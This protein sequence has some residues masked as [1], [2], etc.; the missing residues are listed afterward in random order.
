MELLDAPPGL[1]QLNLDHTVIR[2][3]IDGNQFKRRTESEHSRQHQPPIQHCIDR[4]KTSVLDWVTF[5]ET[6]DDELS[7][8][9]IL[10]TPDLDSQDSLL[11]EILKR[12]QANLPQRRI[13]RKRNKKHHKH[14]QGFVALLSLD[15][16]TARSVAN[17]SISIETLTDRLT[18]RFPSLEKLWT[19]QQQRFKKPETFVRNLRERLQKLEKSRLD[20][21]ADLSRIEYQ[22]ERDNLFFQQIPR[23][24]P[25]LVGK[26]SSFD[27]IDLVKNDDG[28]TDSPHAVKQAV[29][30]N[31]K[32]WTPPAAPFN[33]SS[34]NEWISYYNTHPNVP[35]DFST[36]LLRPVEQ[37]EINTVASST[38]SYKAPGPSGIQAASV[39]QGMNILGPILASLFTRC[40]QAGRI[41]GAWTKSHVHPITKPGATKGDFSKLRPIALLETVRKIFFRVLVNRI[42]DPLHL[43][44]TFCPWQ[45]GFT[46]GLQCPYAISTIRSVID[47]HNREKRPLFLVSFDIR[48]AFDSVS[49]PSLLASLRRFGIPQELQDITTFMY[50]HRKA[51]VH[52]AFGLT[53]PFQPNNGLDQGDTLSPLLWIIFYDALLRRIDDSKLGVVLDFDKRPV[54]N[55]NRINDIILSGLAVADDLTLLA[56]S[57]E[58]AL[59]LIR[60]VDT[61]LQLHGITCNGDKSVIACNHPR[62]HPDFPVPVDMDSSPGRPVSDIRSKDQPVKILG[63]LLRLDG[64]STDAITQMKSRAAGL[65]NAFRYRQ[66]SS[67]IV[68]YFANGVLLP[69]IAWRAWG[70]TFTEAQVQSIA[71][72][73]R[74]TLKNKMRLPSTTPNI[75]L[76]SDETYKVKPLQDIIDEMNIGL[77]ID[78]LNLDHPCTTVLLQDLLSFQYSIGRE[79]FPLAAVRHIKPLP[80]DRLHMVLHRLSTRELTIRPSPSESR[81]LKP[82][83]TGPPIELL[84][85]PDTPTSDL[86]AYTR[87]SQNNTISL[88]D[89]DAPQIPVVIPIIYNHRRI[90]VKVSQAIEKLR[91]FAYDCSKINSNELVRILKDPADPA[92][93]I[94]YPDRGIPSI[95]RSDRPDNHASCSYPLGYP[96]IT[97]NQP[98]QARRTTRPQTPS[99]ELLQEA[100]PAQIEPIDPETYLYKFKTPRGQI[101]LTKDA[102][103]QCARH[104]LTDEY[105]SWAR[106]NADFHVY[107]DGSV[108]GSR[109]GYALAFKQYTADINFTT[110]SHGFDGP[111]ITSNRTE[112][113]AILHAVTLFSNASTLLIQ[114][115]SNV[116]VLAF[117]LFITQN[118]RWSNR[119]KLNHPDAIIWFLVAQIINETGLNVK[120]KHI[121][122][123]TGIPG[124]EQADVTAKK[125]ARNNYGYIWNLNAAY[126]NEQ[127]FLLTVLG[128]HTTRPVKKDLEGQSNRARWDLLQETLRSRLPPHLRMDTLIPPRIDAPRSRQ[129]AH[130]TNI[131]AIAP[132]SPENTYDRATDS[133]TNKNS[134][135]AVA[136]S[137]TNLIPYSDLNIYYPEFII[138]R[139]SLKREKR[140]QC[141][142]H[143]IKGLLN[144]LPT[145]TRHA[146]W[147]SHLPYEGLCPQCLSQYETRKH[148]FTC[149]EIHLDAKAAFSSAFTEAVVSTAK[150]PVRTKRW[151]TSLST[152]YGNIFSIDWIHLGVIPKIEIHRLS[153]TAQI[154]ES[155]ATKAILAGI[156]A[157]REIFL[158]QIWRPRCKSMIAWEK[159]N[160][161]KLSMKR[162]K[163][164]KK[165][166]SND[167]PHSTTQQNTTN[168]M[169]FDQGSSVHS[170][171]AMTQSAGNNEGSNVG[172]NEGSNV[173]NN[174]GNTLVTVG[175]AGSNMHVNQWVDGQVVFSEMG[176][177]G[178]AT[179]FRCHSQRDHG[180][181]TGILGCRRIVASVSHLREHIKARNPA[182][183]TTVGIAGS[184]IHVNQWV[185]GQDVLSE[186]GDGGKATPFRCHSQRDHGL[187]TGILGCRRIVASASHLREHIKV[188][189]P[190]IDPPNG[191]NPMD[192]DDEENSIHLDDT[193]LHHAQPPA[194]TTTTLNA[195]NQLALDLFGPSA[196][197]PP[198]CRLVHEPV[199]LK[200]DRWKT[201]SYELINS[202]YGAWKL[203]PISE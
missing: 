146:E 23:F 131:D 126:T 8:A 5:R 97:A 82:P 141:R 136:N 174:V 10:S 86:Q 161:I 55:S 31:F 17:G 142:S 183:N 94:I 43:S 201:Y 173:G 52:T 159:A 180:L 103:L 160:K 33:L 167:P 68:T 50:E 147:L 135:T 54:E 165:S 145:A 184:N 35:Q 197:L 19:D 70:Q 190:E 187:S 105:Y 37:E 59:A 26:S 133:S 118:S 71:A 78:I 96:G 1:D 92:T 115:D 46:A 113:L 157:A 72:K 73:Y 171:V 15:K 177:G 110:I 76:E 152:A 21:D 77:L 193:H 93:P 85:A 3:S 154:P 162:S 11:T 65:M 175:I 196:L 95:P 107:T 56:P 179:P 49:L 75:I 164:S 4:S 47:I 112:A 163:T 74:G 58:A 60:I 170:E 27:S 84:S 169:V 121:H 176:D 2:I 168:A 172:N 140:S 149:P 12:A 28:V 91:V 143:H 188:R 79:G 194:P 166:A 36:K 51:Q 181:S 134:E 111:C 139:K 9:D 38:A 182:T 18:R 150:H 129:K 185:D 122:G 53:D 138:R 14:S 6:L 29:R 191:L 48:R 83:G 42:A 62:S 120:L 40:L 104:Q 98:T 22:I 192:K 116:A 108:I 20:A 41:P 13:A 88:F 128:V 144:I 63:T 137:S 100:D 125:A 153:S 148:L 203:M 80:H 124:N 195:H 69:C 109:G 101:L 130:Q 87:L 119:R 32:N 114:T 16:K 66:V 178:K 89:L 117:D 189:N 158:K 57:S 30:D 156:T 24:L 151:I 186:M 132:S 7:N 67:D 90:P 99:L 123:H 198:L 200:K 39:K 61:F 155:S 202:V 102:L 45:F 81:F 64:K 44:S 25:A 34:F 127:R 106:S 199:N